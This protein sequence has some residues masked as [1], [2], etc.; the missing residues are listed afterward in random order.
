MAT[1]NMHGSIKVKMSEVHE[2]ITF[3]DFVELVDK[4]AKIL[5]QW[6]CRSLISLISNQAIGLVNKKTVT[7]PLLGNV[8]EVE[9]IK[10]PT[11]LFLK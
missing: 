6:Y 4:S 2:V 10:S 1:D 9:I 7:I 11:S 5:S 3:D 8:V